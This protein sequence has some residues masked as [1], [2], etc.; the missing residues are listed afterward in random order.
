[1]VESLI[2]PCQ[3][4]GIPD[5][6]CQVSE[7]GVEHPLHHCRSGVR[8]PVPHVGDSRHRLRI[9]VV[10]GSR[11]QRHLGGRSQVSVYVFTPEG[12]TEIGGPRPLRRC[13]QD[14]VDQV[15]EAG[16]G[17]IV[18]VDVEHGRVLVGNVVHDWVERDT[19]RSR[20]R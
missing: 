18:A 20:G 10:P 3:R 7:N 1:M 14:Q 5:A 11:W 17:L 2:S 16:R 19:R 6:E 9:A 15:S 12:C 8:C 13:D 4:L